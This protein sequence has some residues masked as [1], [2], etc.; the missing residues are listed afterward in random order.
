MAT[1]SSTHA[2]SAPAPSSAELEEKL[3][4][5]KK[6]SA[7]KRPL[8][9]TKAFV[10]TAI[11]RSRGESMMRQP[12]TPAALQPR[13]MHSVSDCLPHAPERRKRSSSKNAAR[14]R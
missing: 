3:R 9:G 13:P 7:G 1:D 12:V 4:Q 6:I 10:A 8:H 11:S 5:M 2:V 14:G